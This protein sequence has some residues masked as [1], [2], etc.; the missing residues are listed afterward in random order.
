MRHRAGEAQ[1]FDSG[2][3]VMGD[4]IADIFMRPYNYKV[5]AVPPDMQ[6]AWLGERWPP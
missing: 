6:C 3:E 4:G 1:N 2:S 5:W